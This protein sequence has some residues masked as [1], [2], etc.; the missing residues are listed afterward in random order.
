LTQD[1]SMAC[2]ERYIGS[3]IVFDPPDGTPRYL[4]HLESYFGP[5]GDAVSVGAR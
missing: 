3:E 5:F 2:A 1:R 4:A